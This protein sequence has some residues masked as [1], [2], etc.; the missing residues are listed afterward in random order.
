MRVE[1]VLGVGFYFVCKLVVNF[2][3]VLYYV[4]GW[5]LV[6]LFGFVFDCIDVWFV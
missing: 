4:L 1:C 6:W 3:F 5:C 2:W